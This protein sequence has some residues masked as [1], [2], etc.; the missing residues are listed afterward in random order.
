MKKNWHF[1]GVTNLYHVN[2]QHFFNFFSGTKSR[3]TII[4]TQYCFIIK[5]YSPRI[6][7]KIPIQKNNKLL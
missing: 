1:H 3:T 2:Y 4:C 5:K 6:D 7:L